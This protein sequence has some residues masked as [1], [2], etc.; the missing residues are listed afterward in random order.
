METI[1]TT[2]PV[3][4]SEGT[5]E[6]IDL[7]KSILPPKQDFTEFVLPKRINNF[8]LIKLVPNFRSHDDAR[9]L[10]DIPSFMEKEKSYLLYHLSKNGD[11]CV[12]FCVWDETRWHTSTLVPQFNPV[13]FPGWNEGIIL[14]L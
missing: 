1:L 13:S 5:K 11:K 9:Y 8:N 3:F 12:T 10:V 6:M 7:E 2:N 14:L 4:F